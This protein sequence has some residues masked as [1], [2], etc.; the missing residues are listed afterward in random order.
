MILESA[1]ATPG[2]RDR[3]ASPATLATIEPGHRDA[4]PQIGIGRRYTQQIG[5]RYAVIA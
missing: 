5:H 3:I 1:D 2:R 4:V